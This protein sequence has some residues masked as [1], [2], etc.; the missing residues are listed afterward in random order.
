VVAGE[1]APAVD[2]EDELPQRQ[3]VPENGQ[4]LRW[5]N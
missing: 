4:G 1:I 3:H 5:M 2:L